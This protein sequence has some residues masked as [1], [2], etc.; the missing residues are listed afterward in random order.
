MAE[1]H[2]PLLLDFPDQF[3]TERLI[4]RAPRPGDAPALVEAVNTSLDHLRPW[5]P[6]AAQPSTLE[7]TEQ[8][9]RLGA[10]RWLA[11]ED[12]WLMLIRKA[13]G[14]WLGGSD[15][16]LGGSD[17]W[18]GG[19]GLHRIN[20]RVPHFEIGY[21]IRAS[22]EG[23]GYVTEAVNGITAFAFDVLGAERVM[24]RCDSLNTRSAAVAERCGY[25]FEGLMLHDSRGVDDTLRDT[26]VYSLIRPEWLARKETPHA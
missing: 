9:L 12:L 23:Q 19:S 8:R 25:T 13:D 2:N 17:R 5:M 24:I 22:A 16:W 20:W 18:L 7:E 14:H 21:W 1:S 15:R 6:W 4:I 26:R 10:A 3:E 11:R